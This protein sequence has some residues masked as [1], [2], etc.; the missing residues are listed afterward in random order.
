MTHCSVLAALR[1][2]R[3]EDRIIEFSESTHTVAEA[4]QA[5]GCRPHDI[6]KSVALHLGEGAV[7]V[8]CAGD[9]KIDNARFKAV[10][11]EKARMLSAEET[12]A[13]TGFE[14]GGVSPLGLPPGVRL[15][16]DVSLLDCMEVYPAGGDF[17]TVLRLTLNELR[18]SCVFDGVV[19]VA[20]KR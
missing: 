6:A 17:H 10:F 11:G 15:F 4:A 18:S 1:A 12:P 2:G 5:I 3:L 16:L 14:P 9:H 8:L 13:F 20:V 7:V 19:E